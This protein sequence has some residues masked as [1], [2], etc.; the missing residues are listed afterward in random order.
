MNIFKH[1]TRVGR[2]IGKGLIAGAEEWFESNSVFEYGISD[3][4]RDW[5]SSG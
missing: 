3:S 5:F 4:H 1:I 2:G